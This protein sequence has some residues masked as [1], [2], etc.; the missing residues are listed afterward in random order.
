MF[1]KLFKGGGLSLDRLRVLCEVAE[2]GSIATAAKGN[3]V[4]QSQYSRQLKELEDFFEVELTRRHG[5]GLVLTQAGREL[6]EQSRASLKG[7]EDFHLRWINQPL[8]YSIGAG[9]SLL[10]WLLLPSLASVDTSTPGASFKLCN[11]RTAKIVGGLQDLSLDFGLVRREAVT[12]SLTA[13]PLGSIEYAVYCPRELVTNGS[14]PDLLSVLQS[15]PLAILG[16]DGEFRRDFGAWVDKN[17]LH[18]KVG[19]E[20]DSFPQAC[21]AV[22]TKRFAAVLPTIAS[23][24]LPAVD[25]VKFDLPL[26]KGTR[27]ICLAWNPRTLRLRTSASMVADFLG[28]VLKF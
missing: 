10:E 1:E 13:H 2:A 27:G 28:K 9:E 14:K 7:L 24:D 19:L 20:C 16:S 18:I 17:H 8:I 6:V 5:K 12:K 23:C 21:R 3:P 22:R 11:L 26:E 25:F 4:R 15:V